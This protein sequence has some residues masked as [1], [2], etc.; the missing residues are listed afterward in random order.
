MFDNKLTTDLKQ[1][2]EYSFLFPVSLPKKRWTNCIL[3]LI[4]SIFVMFSNDY[5]HQA[6]NTLVLFLGFAINTTKHNLLE[7][8][9]GGISM[10]LLTPA[11]CE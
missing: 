10:A 2:I 3:L 9:R 7:A 11:Q 6:E 5:F 8:V 1:M 4:V